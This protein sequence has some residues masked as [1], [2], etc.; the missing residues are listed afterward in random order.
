MDF[1][2]ARRRAGLLQR[3]VAE[4]LGVSTSTVAMWDIGKNK[5]KADMLP[6][7]AMLYGCTVDDLLGIQNAE[8]SGIEPN[9]KDK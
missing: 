6:K 3:Q 1:S 7:I 2:Y 9:Q 4:S 5:P 8:K